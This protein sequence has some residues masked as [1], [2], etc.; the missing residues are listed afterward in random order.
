MTGEYS[1][2][3]VRSVSRHLNV[4]SAEPMGAFS[5]E[6]AAVAAWG[7]IPS[8]MNHSRDIQPKTGRR[9]GER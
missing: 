4:W 6:A 5:A 8:Q 7:Q 3:M 1:K 9:K 2:S